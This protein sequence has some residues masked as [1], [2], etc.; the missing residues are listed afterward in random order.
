MERI[1]SYSELPCLRRSIYL[2]METDPGLYVA[3]FSKGYKLINNINDADET[4]IYVTR[5]RQDYNCKSD[6]EYVELL[7][8]S[9][10]TT[11]A[12]SG[13]RKP[14]TTRFSYQDLIEHKYKLP[15]VFK[16]ENANGGKEKFLIST[17][18]DYENLIKACKYL[19]GRTFLLALSNDQNKVDIDYIDYLDSNFVIQEYIQTPSEFNTTVRLIT[20]PSDDL[21]YASLRYNKPRIYQDKTTLVGHLLSKVYPLSAKSIV[22]NIVTGGEGVLIGESN[23]SQF[24]RELLN[25]HNI[26]S[27]QFH[28]LV[29]ASE[30]V[31]RKHK[32]ELGIICGFDYI[33]DEE[34]KE[35]HLLEYHTVPMFVDYAR[36]QGV[37]YDTREDRLVA[38]GR[39][40]ATA[41]SLELKKTR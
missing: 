27:E 6:K 32:S 15:F 12:S 17:E 41:L 33:Y 39:V 21:L 19:R 28:E 40:R 31:H 7:D 35:W 18:E 11:L 8:K 37:A 16:N 14:S 3:L 34:K 25:L 4:T 24:E 23:Y 30:N 36:R 10:Q 5:R 1:I 38:D 29:E 22:S 13:I 2:R 9:I 20:T 26:D